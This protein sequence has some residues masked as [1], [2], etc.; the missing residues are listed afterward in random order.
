MAVIHFHNFNWKYDLSY[1]ECGFVDIIDDEVIHGNILVK[2]QLINQSL[3]D[4]YMQNIK[5][6]F[7]TN[8]I[9]WKK[10]YWIKKQTEMDVQYFTHKH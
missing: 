6:Y 5:K 8:F 10:E 7:K 1:I 4:I 9:V 2:K 3:R